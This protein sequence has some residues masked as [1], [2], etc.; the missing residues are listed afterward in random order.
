MWL[1]LSGTSWGLLRREIMEVKLHISIASNENE[2]RF[3]DALEKL[4]QRF[5]DS[6]NDY[7]FRFK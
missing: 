7:M 5:A 3:V 1:L 2:Q 6:K 4:C